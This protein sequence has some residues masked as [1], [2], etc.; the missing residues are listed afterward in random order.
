[1]FYE[2]NITWR[3]NTVFDSNEGRG[4]SRFFVDP[5]KGFLL[6]SE[7]QVHIS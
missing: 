1:M 2:R 3:R 4:A 6:K 5:L 7:L